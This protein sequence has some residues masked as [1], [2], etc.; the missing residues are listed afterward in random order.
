[1]FVW[2]LF[3]LILCKVLFSDYVKNEYSKPVALV[4]ILTS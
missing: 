3:M 1:M 2:A 4:A